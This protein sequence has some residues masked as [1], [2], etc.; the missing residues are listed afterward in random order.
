MSY[1]K[2]V[3]LWCDAAECQEW[4]QLNNHESKGGKVAAARIPVVKARNQAAC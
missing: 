4:T 2:E 3:T 1:T